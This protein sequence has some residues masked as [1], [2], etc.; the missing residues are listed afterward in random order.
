VQIIG[1]SKSPSLPP[2]KASGSPLP[3]VPSPGPVTLTI[4]REV[5][6]KSAHSTPAPAAS[7]AASSSS[8][9]APATAKKVKTEH[10]QTHKAALAADGLLSHAFY[11]RCCVALPEVNAHVWLCVA[12]LNAIEVHLTRFDEYLTQFANTFSNT[13]DIPYSGLQIAA[14]LPPALCAVRRA[15]SEP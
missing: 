1:E 9:A 4:K 3:P 15:S 13:S 11:L 7:A 2:L 12:T 8:A 6:A 10:K 14:L 5:K